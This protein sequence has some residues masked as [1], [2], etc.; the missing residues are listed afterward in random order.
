[1]TCL[2]SHMW[3]RRAA[4]DR[5]VVTVGE[6]DRTNPAILAKTNPERVCAALLPPH[7]PGWTG[8][9]GGRGQS[10]H[11]GNFSKDVR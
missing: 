5:K 6:S 2:Y 10:T 3:L 7:K 11:Y 1:M 8:A 4:F 9:G